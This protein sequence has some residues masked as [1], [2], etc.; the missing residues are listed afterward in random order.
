MDNMP[1]P[2]DG[3]LDGGENRRASRGI[4]EDIPDGITLLRASEYNDFALKYEIPKRIP[5]KKL[6]VYFE[7]DEPPYE[8]NWL[9]D[10]QN[11]CGLSTADCAESCFSQNFS[12]LH[13]LTLQTIMDTDEHGNIIRFQAYPDWLR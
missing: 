12:C 1:Y 13:H 3:S 8:D 5:D 6:L 9:L 4:L 11:R 10:I 2:D 7:K